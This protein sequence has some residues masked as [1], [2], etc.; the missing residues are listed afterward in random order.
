MAGNSGSSEA[1]QILKAALI[2]LRTGG[3]KKK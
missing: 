1:S 2:L 3:G